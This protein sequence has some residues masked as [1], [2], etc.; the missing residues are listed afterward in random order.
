M[1]YC[2]FEAYPCLPRR[3]LSNPARAFFGDT[4]SLF[5]F[6]NNA[7]SLLSAMP[8][9]T[10]PPAVEASFTDGTEPSV[11]TMKCRSEVTIY[12]LGCA[13]DT[14]RQED[15]NLAFAGGGTCAPFFTRTRK[16][17][18]SV[19]HDT[20]PFLTQPLLRQEKLD[21]RPSPRV[22]ER[23]S[24]CGPPPPPLPTPDLILLLS[25]QILDIE[26]FS[27][28]PSACRHHHPLPTTYTCS[29][30]TRTCGASRSRT[31]PPP[32]TPSSSITGSP[33]SS[34]RSRR[35]SCPSSRARWR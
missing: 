22:L 13:G 34:C 24:S 5:L 6:V 33:A 21:F 2:T 11:S 16:K 18:D 17:I 1:Y 32:R 19:T 15:T 12:S 9:K 27:L 3:L 30:A 29:R 26:L 31:T 35:P 23:C 7:P 8:S 25:Y 14:C 20:V 28:V 4:E 10:T